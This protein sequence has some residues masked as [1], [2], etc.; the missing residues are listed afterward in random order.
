MQM[1]GSGENKDENE[2]QRYKTDISYTYTGISQRSHSKAEIIIMCI[3]IPLNT[4]S[5]TFVMLL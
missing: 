2:P 1:S 4:K 5:P 3:R